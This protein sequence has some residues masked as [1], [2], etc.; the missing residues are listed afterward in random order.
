[1][2]SYQVLT[3]F[4]ITVLFKT[5]F[6]KN[7]LKPNAGKNLRSFV[8]AERDTVNKF[9]L[10]QSVYLVVNNCAISHQCLVS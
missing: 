3:C 1:M 7:S 2:L 5:R 9:R 8:T 4:P 10:A 6:K